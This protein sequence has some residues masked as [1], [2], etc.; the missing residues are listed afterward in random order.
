MGKPIANITALLGT[1][2]ARVVCLR[3]PRY[4]KPWDDGMIDRIVAEKFGM[5]LSGVLIFFLKFARDSHV[6]LTSPVS[7]HTNHT[8]YH[9][10]ISAHV[11]DHV[12]DIMS[13]LFPVAQFV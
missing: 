5:P 6:Q 4:P 2:Q 9:N 7:R 10:S 1:T 8:P 11:T 3:P 12:I 13:P